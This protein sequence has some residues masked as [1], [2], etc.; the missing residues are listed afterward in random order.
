[1][2]NACIKKTTTPIRSFIH[3]STYA[4]RFGFGFGLGSIFFQEGKTKMKQNSRQGGRK[5]AKQHHVHF[6]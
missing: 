5:R 4:W 3:P 1:M 6:P 2:Y